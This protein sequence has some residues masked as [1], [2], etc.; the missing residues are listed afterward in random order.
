ENVHTLRVVLDS[1][2]H[3]VSKPVD[4]EDLAG[5]RDAARA[6]RGAELDADAH[7]IPVVVIALVVGFQLGERLRDVLVKAAQ[8]I[9]A[10]TF[11]TVSPYRDRAV[12]NI[13]RK[14]LWVTVAAFPRATDDLDVLPRHRLL[15]QA[16]VGEGAVG[17][18]V[19]YESR[20]DPPSDVKQ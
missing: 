2:D 12:D 3:I 17:G 15:L 6:R 11:L 10:A 1:D 16:E 5:D 20:H 18:G 13:G 19:R 7:G 8:L 9:Q 14:E 4:R